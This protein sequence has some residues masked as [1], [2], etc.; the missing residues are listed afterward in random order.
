MLDIPFNTFF[1]PK[2]DNGYKVF[3]SNGPQIKPPHDTLILKSIL[4]HL[5]IDDPEAYNDDLYKF[6]ED[7]KIDPTKEMTDKYYQTL[8]DLLFDESL[9]E[10][11]KRNIVYTAMHGVGAAFIDQAFAMAKFRPVVHVPEQQEPDPEFPT[12]AFPNPE[13]GTPAAAL[14]AIVRK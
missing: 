2:E 6:K 7:L 1:T 5:Q 12:A 11:F 10:G 4:E 13:E 9:N 3:W 14:C 8:K